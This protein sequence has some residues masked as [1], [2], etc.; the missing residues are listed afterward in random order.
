MTRRFGLVRALHLV[1]GTDVSRGVVN[2]A[3]AWSL[4]QTGC[5]YDVCMYYGMYSTSKP[6][7]RRL[8]SSSGNVHRLPKDPSSCPPRSSTSMSLAYTDR[9]RRLHPPCG[10]VDVPGARAG[11]G[12]GA[13]SVVGRRHSDRERYLHNPVRPALMRL[14]PSLSFRQGKTLDSPTLPTH[15]F[16]SF[17]PGLH[18][19]LFFSFTFFLSSL[20]RWANAVAAVTRLFHSHWWGG[21]PI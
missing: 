3:I 18:L 2:T 8:T 6:H 5:M 1:P 11:R 13:G 12:C 4:L 16:F 14:G 7:A 10:A 17:S 9:N 19:D 20:S 15:V 21:L